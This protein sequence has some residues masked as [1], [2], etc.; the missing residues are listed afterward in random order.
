[1]NEADLLY[2]RPFSFEVGGDKVKG[3]SLTRSDGWVQA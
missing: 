3:K 1:M 2:N